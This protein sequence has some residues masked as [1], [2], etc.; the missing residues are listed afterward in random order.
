M[1]RYLD[2]RTLDDVAIERLREFEAAALAKHPDGYYLAFS[3]GKDSVV[4]LDLAKRG[5]VKFTA[6]HH[7]TTV[8][9]P[10]LVYFVRT[11]PEV[12]I[13]RPEK[14]L[15]D[16]MVEKGVAP[17]RNRRWCCQE[18][19]ENGGFGRMVVTGIRWGESNRRSKR[20]MTEACFRGK[21][22]HLLN[23]IIDWST[24]DVWNYIH[25]RGL[26]YCSLYDEGWD[27]VGCVLCPL[28]RDTERQMARWPKIAAKW[29]RAVKRT[30]RPDGGT[31]KTPDAYWR[32][33]LDRDA[34][35]DTSTDPVLFED[36]PAMG[37]GK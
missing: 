26:L 24:D 28:V 12:T 22:K 9:P 13:H 36:D 32:W 35:L 5:G 27:R 23:P 1:N 16:R 34:H 20:R 15:C 21:G 7:L 10:E 11:F 18:Y 37:V 3:G 17:T 33:W 31:I 14:H 8:D 29:Q 30:W 4:I 25:Q 6:H 19:K 2:G